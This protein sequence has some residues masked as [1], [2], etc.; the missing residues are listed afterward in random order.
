MPSR[1]T[2]L[3][4]A[5]LLAGSPGA[6]V[7][8]EITELVIRHTDFDRQLNQV[9]MDYCQG[10]RR[11]GRLRKVLLDPVGPAVFRVVVLA[12]LVN[13]HDAGPML[14]LGGGLGWSYTVQV[15]AVGTLSSSNCNLRVDR[16]D[17]IDDRLGLAGL[18]K[19]EEGKIHTIPDCKRFL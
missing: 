12:D 4:L 5:L 19:A 8:R 15:K 2:T 6:I 14:G 7:A 17:V 18:V 9:C 11:S 3:L 16:V 1:I 10:N 13:E